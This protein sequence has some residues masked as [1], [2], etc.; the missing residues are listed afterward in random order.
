MRGEPHPSPSP[1]RSLPTPPDP[2]LTLPILP[3]P[4]LSFPTP[5]YPSILSCLF[6]QSARAG[7]ASSVFERR[8][9]PRKRRLDVRGWLICEEVLRELGIQSNGHRRRRRTGGGGGMFPV[10]VNAPPI[11]YAHV[12]DFGACEEKS[13]AWA[14]GPPLASDHPDVPLPNCMSSFPSL[15]QPRML[16]VG[17]PCHGLLS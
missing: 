12:P 1:S 2:S 14:G 11:C 5:P 9:G 8:S 15:L 13:P 6:L 7:Q 16:I 17:E 3:H 4:S 10:P